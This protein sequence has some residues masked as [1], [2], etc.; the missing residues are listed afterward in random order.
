M[1]QGY[2]P[3]TFLAVTPP[4]APAATA[5][6][7][8]AQTS[9]TAN[10]TSAVSATGYKLDV[11]TSNTF[12]TLV[13]GYSNKDVG[14][15]IFYSVT[16]L[17]ANT[18]YY[19]RVRAY[20][21]GGDSPNSNVISPITLP[22]PPAAPVATEATTF[23]QTTFSANWNNTAS[24]TGYR[25]DVATDNSF[26]SILAAY[27]NRDV[28]NVTTYS[29]TGLTANTQYYY[30]IRAYN[31]G[32]TSA[33]SNTI[34]STTLINPP[35]APVAITAD[36]IAQT[37][38]T[39]KWNSSATATSYWLD[40]ATDNS[41]SNL[42]AGYSNLDV[43]NVTSYGITGLTANTN[44]YYRVRATNAGG[45]S[46]NS[47]TISATTLINPPAAPVATTANPIG[48]TDFAA[49]WNAAATATG[50]RLDVST[51][52]TFATLLTGYS[53]L[54]LTNVTTYTVSGLTASTTYYY[55]IR[56]YNAGGT[57]SNSNI[58]PVTTT[59]NPPS[60]PSAPGAISASGIIQ[61]SFT[62]NWNS[63][64]TAT[65]YRLDISANSS[66]DSFV[67]G[68]NNKDVNNVLT[69]NV[70]GLIQNTQY[71]YRV[72]AYNSGGSSASS[73]TISALT[74]P[75]PPAAP[76][77][78]AA[79]DILQTE[80][81]SNWSSSA[82]ATGYRL[83]IATDNIFTNVVT[84]YND[85][86]AG[87][88]TSYSVSGLT[89]N[90]TYYYR[91]RAYN[92]GGTSE[93]SNI[94]TVSTTP[95]PPAAPVATAGNNLTQTSLSANW[96]SS[97]NA[98][99]YKLDVSANSSFTSIITGYNDLDVGNVMTYNVPGLTGGTTYY[100]RIRAYNTG[101]S[102]GNSNTI[103]VITLTPPSPPGA[104]VATAPVSI[105]QT[106]FTATWN[107]STGATGYKLDVASDNEFTLLIS[108]FSN[109]DVSNVTNYTVTG[110]TAK[111]QYYYRIR[112]YNTNGT[113]GNSNIIEAV[114][115][116]NPPAAPVGLSVK[117]CNDLV[118]LSWT[119]NSEPDVLKYIIF[120]GFNAN[121]VQRI[122]STSSN[123]GVSSITLTGLTHN[124]E[125]TL[126]IA[127]VL[128]P[129]IE[130]DYSSEV[131]VTVKT[132]YIPQIV[133]KWGAVLVCSNI[134]DSISDYRWFKENDPLTGSEATKQ[135][136]YTN[137]VAG[138]Y[139]VEIT[140]KDGCKNFSNAISVSAKASLIVYPN[141]A[142]G[143]A[144]IS[145]VDEPVGRAVISI[146]SQTGVKLLEFK[147]EKTNE[148][149]IEEI[150]VSHLDEGMYFVKVVVNDM[151]EYYSKI[152]IVK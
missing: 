11:S 134:N 69:F 19:Y 91:V 44:Y 6:T 88:I 114:T 60:P 24:A 89:A 73:N 152:I 4:S 1:L 54:D 142:K 82:T 137:E 98:T 81:T 27:S 21:A 64:S 112:A 38:F 140:D 107:G 141:P 50:Y 17:T 145:L 101:G 151:H 80:F 148:R 8:L 76:V 48:Q 97:S 13:T 2:A 93:N 84:G 65:G 128:S 103:T 53:N 123:S 126:R 33:N 16:G 108:G 39:A 75:D 77:A 57:S 116:P 63:S 102:S 67:T 121:P 90:T 40:I 68:Y 58:I 149:L 127:A 12:S 36:P 14:N 139:K 72:R 147:T 9:L 49:N 55:R 143:N 56:A 146:M 99:G 71:Y 106:S 109:L 118:T 111:S 59:L 129:G 43:S 78:S 92:T 25:I 46:T 41:F 83:D 105:K 144:D 150:Q 10:W 110:L 104:P 124:K 61:T 18:Q 100:Y 86:D 42:L 5:A 52:N 47:N 35:A 131:K 15:A 70:T 130:G 34:S 94:I 138:L 29:I 28:N 20:N 132:G 23:A 26:T 7:D 51:S 95:S 79:S 62:A 115:L 3:T 30:R 119:P 87:N 66:F 133:L 32:G 125:Y 37:T 117:S 85:L 122:D 120:G 96:N 135:Y 74:L 31:T 22:D 45:T 136:Y 113:S